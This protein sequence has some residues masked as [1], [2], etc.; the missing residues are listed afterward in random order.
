MSFSSHL[1]PRPLAGSH[2]SHH[3]DLLSE[4][5]ASGEVVPSFQRQNAQQITKDEPKVIAK[6]WAHF[7]AGGYVN[8][9]P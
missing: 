5:R 6:P 3:D 4:S 1:A 2:T 7:V 8:I 9:K